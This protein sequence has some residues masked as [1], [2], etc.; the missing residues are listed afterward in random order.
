MKEGKTLLLT[1][2]FMEESEALSDRI[3]MITDG[4][5]RAEGTPEKLKEQFGSGFDR[6]YR[7]LFSIFPR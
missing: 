6:L 2:H 3:I 1:T 4:V 5:I 7:I